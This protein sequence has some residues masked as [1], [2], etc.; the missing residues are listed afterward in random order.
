MIRRAKIAATHD[1]TEAF[2]ELG[3]AAR[4]YAVFGSA[5]EEELRD[6]VTADLI[7]AAVALVIQLA[8]DLADRDPI[9]MRALERELIEA[10]GAEK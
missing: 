7:G 2:A 6:R 5:G 9:K 8:I 10:V 1:A 4:H 3:S